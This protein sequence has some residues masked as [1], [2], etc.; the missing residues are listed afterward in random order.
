VSLVLSRYR[1]PLA[2]GLLLYAG[3]AVAATVD[4]I[5]EGRRRRAAALAAVA[6]ALGGLV[7]LDLG[8]GLPRFRPSEP[9]GIAQLYHARGRP[10]DAAR[11]I[12]EALPRF[13]DQPRVAAL[14]HRQAAGYRARAGD[15]PRARQHLDAALALEEREAP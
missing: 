15:A 3:L 14:L 9:A 10:A 13:A 11:V 6:L 8:V 7:A 1:M 5:R 4:A 12:E 2:T